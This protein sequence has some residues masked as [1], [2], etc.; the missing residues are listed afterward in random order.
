MQAP[1]EVM[2]VP[3]HPL[4]MMRHM[5][6]MKVYQPPTAATAAVSAAARPALASGFRVTAAQT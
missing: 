4:K 1:S 3:N 6:V 5:T 2:Q